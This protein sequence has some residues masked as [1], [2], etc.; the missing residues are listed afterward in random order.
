M[1]PG[2]LVV[3]VVALTATACSTSGASSPSSSVGGNSIGITA[4]TVTVGQV[5][6]LTG[7]VPGL[8]E[9]AENGTL[10]YFDYVNSQGGVNG[11]K[12]KLDVKDDTFSGATYVTD[13]QQLVSSD[14]ALVGGFSL[15]DD[16][17]VP[18]INA[19][20]IPDITESLS[21]AR[22]TD[23]YNYAPD[24]LI[25]GGAALGPLTYYKEKF[26]SAIKHVG[27]LFSN[28]ATAEVQSEAELNAMKSIG[29]KVGYQRITGPLESNFIPDVLKMRA[30]G[31][32]MV[33]I[34]GLAVT[35]VA[36]L[37]QQMKQENFTPQV[38]A[39]SGVAYDSS[40]IPAAGAAANG[41]YTALQTPLFLGQDAA[42]V[43]AVTLLDKWV[44]KVSPSAHIDLYALYGWSSGELFV[45]ALQA[46]GKNPTRTTLI[47]A[48]NKITLFN[49]SGLLA[50]GNPAQKKPE[51]CW[52]LATVSGGKWARTAPSPKSGFVCNPGGYYYPSGFKPFTR[53]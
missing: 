13:T 25:V 44:K 12:I 24:P 21:Q 32:Q 8:F 19:A 53:P 38:F 47:S 42:T 7:P 16:A 20:K 29:Y 52:I 51:Q 34:V 40:Y 49:A 46:A 1:M 41:T 26:P 28:V 48:L 22:G 17:G 4:S 2:I 10:A 5:D 11:R 37:A 33:F 6:T 9:G 45:Q 30:A 14:F 3:L 27:T 50:P 36:D 23:V 15:F 18:A 39:T 31:V 43:P 35:Q